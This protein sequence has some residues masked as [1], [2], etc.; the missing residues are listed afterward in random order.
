MNV[1]GLR[2]VRATL[3]SG[4]IPVSEPLAERGFEPGTSLRT[5]DRTLR[6]VGVAVP[7]FT[8]FCAAV[9][10]RTVHTMIRRIA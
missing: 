9:S 6:F 10:T 8:A 3:R 5:G 1:P 2:T 4:E 7:L